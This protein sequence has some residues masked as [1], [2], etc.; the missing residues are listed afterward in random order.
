[1][2]IWRTIL[3]VFLAANALFWGLFPHTLHCQ[4]V[5]KLGLK[6]CP[7]HYVHLIMG[8]TFFLLALGVAQWDHLTGKH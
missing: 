3:V 8:V 2:E 5:A 6:S 7:P 4:F 1:M